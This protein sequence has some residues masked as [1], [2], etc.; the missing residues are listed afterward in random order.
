[1]VQSTLDIP[2]LQFPGKAARRV[3]LGYFHFGHPG[4]CELEFELHFLML[5][6]FPANDAGAP[7]PRP[8][9]GTSR[10]SRWQLANSKRFAS[11]RLKSGQIR[12]E[13][14]R[15]VLTL[16]KRPPLGIREWKTVLSNSIGEVHRAE[17]QTAIAD[18]LQ[19][20]PRNPYGARR[21]LT[22]VHRASTYLEVEYNPNGS[23]ESAQAG[24]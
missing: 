24:R 14:S 4:R 5:D 17:N 15:L 23:Q 11:F 6:H 3:K 2:S 7:T 13:N 9:E 18:L 8:A 19:K 22:R 20:I 10:E 21:G 16:I 1:M 12:H